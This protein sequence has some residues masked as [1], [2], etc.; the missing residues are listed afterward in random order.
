MASGK[1]EERREKPVRRFFLM[2]LVAGKDFFHDNGPKWAAAIAYYALLSAF[3]L[4]LAAASIA[5]Y[6]VD[7]QWAVDQ[8]TQA[9]DE[10]LPEAS[11]QVEDIVQGAV[12]TRVTASLLSFASLLWTGTRV[13]GAITVALNIAAGSE[14]SYGPLRRT[15]VEIIMLLTLGVVFVLAF[16]GQPASRWLWQV[17]GREAGTWTFRLVNE[18]LPIVFLFAAFL[19]SY[20]FVP[21]NRPT[22]RAALAGASVGILLFLAARALFL[23]YLR[24]MGDYN[25]IYGSLAIAIILLLWAWLVANILILGGEVA[26]HTQAMLVEGKPAEEVERGHLIRSHL[27]RFLPDSEKAGVE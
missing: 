14:Q 25:L 26:A 13:F 20:R 3:P 18:G 24:R 22:W 17:L 12:E 16:V 10:L 1:E 11:G 15:L 4:M 9:M 23:Y 8:L 21:R 27:R 6:F 2:L 5:A 7:P 19:L